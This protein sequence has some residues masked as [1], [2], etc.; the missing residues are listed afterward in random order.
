MESKYDA[1]D[2][3]EMREALSHYHPI[4][5]AFMQLQTT[6]L[7]TPS[8]HIPTLVHEHREDRLNSD[9]HIEKLM[10]VECCTKKCIEIIGEDEV[11]MESTTIEYF[12]SNQHDAKSE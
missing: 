3:A 1:N 11:S 4:G 6:P 9:E 10:K 12:I 8:T 5:S 2:L 7:P